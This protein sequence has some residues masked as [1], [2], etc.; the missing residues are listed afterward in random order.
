MS[1]NKEVLY[2]VKGQV[3][4]VTFNRPEVKNALNPLMRQQ[5]NDAMDAA[6][7]DDN[8]R[9][10]VVAANGDS[11]GAGQDLSAMDDIR[12]DAIKLIDDHIK[13]LL[14]R[15]HHAPKPVIAAINGACAGVSA[16]IAMAC[17]MAVMSDDAF[18]YMAFAAVSLIPDGGASW[19]LVNHLGYKRAYQLVA[20]SGRLKADQCLE[21]GLV[22]KVCP[23]ASL[24]EETLAWAES[25]APRAP[26]SLRLTKEALRN[27]MNLNLADAISAEAPLQKTCIESE[28]S[29]EAMKAFMEKRKP[30]FNGR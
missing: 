28:D 29:R 14:L 16:S 13:P 26:L 20:E 12:M 24:R 22:N 11:F 19:H 17:D 9:V 30:V 23:A 1:E 4:V 2:E 18:I 10:I 3:A 15:I 21:M 5:F 8:V 25:L 7:A 27:S 6:S